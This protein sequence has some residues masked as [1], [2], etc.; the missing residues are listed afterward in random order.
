MKN[1]R[2]FTLR[3]A[4]IVLSVG[5]LVLVGGTAAARPDVPSNL[6]DRPNPVVVTA[7][8]Q[9][10]GSAGTALTYNTEFVPEGA[11]VTVRSVPGVGHGTTTTLVVKGLAPNREYGAH[12]HVNACGPTGDYAGSHFQYVMDPV[13]PSTDPNYAN[14]QNEI[15]L[16]FTTDENGFGVAVS[17]VPWQFAERRAES[18]VI[19]EHHTHTGPGEAGS[20][21]SRFGCVSVDF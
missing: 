5:G 19:H 16:D 7:A 8:F 11:N 4:A 6:P 15:W 12:A 3:A 14:P 2:S 18:I 21:G 10:A 20:A 17:T 9:P 13:Q 1:P